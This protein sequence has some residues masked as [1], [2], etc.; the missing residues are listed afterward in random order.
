MDESASLDSYPNLVGIILNGRYLV[1]DEIGQG[2]FSIVWLAFNVHNH[3]YYAIKIYEADY[4]KYAL[5]EIEIMNKFTDNDVNILNKYVDSFTIDKEVHI[6]FNLMAGSLYEMIHSGLSIE[7]TKVIVY[8]VINALKNL[9][10]YGYIHTDLKPENILVAGIANNIKHIINTLEQNKRFK[11]CIQQYTNAKPN[12]K[13]DFA[14]ELENIV[15]D[16]IDNIIKIDDNVVTGDINSTLLSDFGNCKNADHSK[17]NIQTLCYRAPEI[18]LGY[19][20]D[21]RCDV[22][23]IGCLIFELLT[24]TL[25]FDPER[26]EYENGKRKLLI[27]YINHLGPIPD[28]LIKQSK[29]GTVYFRNDMSMKTPTKMDYT[30]LD[31]KVR[32]A[33]SESPELDE[34]ID[35]LHKVFEY[36]PFNRPSFD[37]C[38]NHP[39]FKNINI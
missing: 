32:Q 34:I 35:F 33:I 26:S 9:H 12:K 2:S 36:D 25:L 20:Y 21:Y 11:K 16:I 29:T 13:K 10:K 31:N 24:G 7:Q 39:W 3:K 14:N 28:Y 27:Q 18:I 17:Y 4:T 22:W 38:L 23:S 6:V 37:E 8:K 15:I 5:L 19:K 30:P 1:I